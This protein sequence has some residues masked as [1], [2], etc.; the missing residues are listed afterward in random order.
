MVKSEVNYS[1]PNRFMK[2]TNQNSEV[3]VTIGA[4]AL[5]LFINL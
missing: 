3:H 1:Q 2:D 4:V 5:W